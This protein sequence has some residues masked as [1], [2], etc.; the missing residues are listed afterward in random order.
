MSEWRWTLDGEDARSWRA[1]IAEPMSARCVSPRADAPRRT[2]TGTASRR[3]KRR[4]TQFVATAVDIN[5]SMVDP[6]RTSVPDWG[7]ATG[8]SCAWLGRIVDGVWKCPRCSAFVLTMD[9]LS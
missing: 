4:A 1:R 3:T 5:R 9:R 6:T 8:V 2:I 7:S